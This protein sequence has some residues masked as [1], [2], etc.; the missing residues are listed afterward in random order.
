[1]DKPLPSLDLPITPR[2]V[3]VDRMGVVHHSHY[4]VYF[5]MGRTELLRQT[6]VNY[7]QLEAE[8]VFFVVAEI[9]CQFKLPA[10]YDQSLILSTRMTRLRRA[11][12]EHEYQLR[13]AD[14]ST[15]ICQ[16]RST[17]ACVDRKGQLQVIPD[18]LSQ[19]LGCG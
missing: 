19:A 11:S 4:F 18:W 12:I 5:E 8:G 7:D 10:R 1:M 6:G 14:Q 2:Y 15:L 3:E 16:A 17:I 9:G 13:R